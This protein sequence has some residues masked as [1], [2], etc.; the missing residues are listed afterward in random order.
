MAQ[1]K[2]DGHANAPFFILRRIERLPE[3]EINKAWES[4]QRSGVIEAASRLENSSTTKYPLGGPLLKKNGLPLGI[5]SP[6]RRV[7]LPV[8]FSHQR[9]GSSILASLSEA[10]GNGR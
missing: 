7:P 6:G 9:V 10:G 5:G 4:G 3:S 8:S 2:A 1:W